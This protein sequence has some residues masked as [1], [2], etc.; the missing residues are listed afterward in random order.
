M[1]GGTDGAKELSNAAAG[2]AL[3]AA[4]QVFEQFPHYQQAGALLGLAPNTQKA[5]HAIDPALLA[6]AAATAVPDGRS[7]S[8]DHEGTGPPRNASAMPPA[9]CRHEPKPTGGCSGRCYQALNGHLIDAAL[10]LRQ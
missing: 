7:I 3:F 2:K 9:V 5:L 4:S 10:L 1:Y 6:A 8:F